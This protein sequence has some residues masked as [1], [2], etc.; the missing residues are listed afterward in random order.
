MGRGG[1]GATAQDETEGDVSML[2][3]ACQAGFYFA[4]VG[5]AGCAVNTTAP[6]NTTL[7]FSIH[8]SASGQ[9]VTVSR[10]LV[11][12]PG[13]ADGAAPCTAGVCSVLG[14]CPSGHPLVVPEPAYPELRLRAEDTQVAYVPAGQAYA[15][16]SAQQGS[17]RDACEGGVQ[18][19]AHAG[20][21]TPDVDMTAR[22]L[23][24]PPD[25][26]MPLGCPGHEF[27]TKGAYPR[28]LRLECSRA[29]Y[30]GLH[31]QACFEAAMAL[32]WRAPAQSERTLRCRP[33]RLRHQHGE[34]SDWRHVPA[35]LSRVQPRHAGAAREL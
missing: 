28:V 24:C 12:L 10:T 7:V 14:L 1:Q 27:T 34:G 23:S 30:G 3:T 19:F 5:L 6:G 21:A 29:A 35:R 16:C 26:C 2:V 9:D 13:C 22:V 11:I 4:R 15:A 18:A 32:Q 25:K 8:D 31:V 33:A 20:D 17:V